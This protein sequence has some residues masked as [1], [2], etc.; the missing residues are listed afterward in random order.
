MNNL[1][2]NFLSIHDTGAPSIVVFKMCMLLDDKCSALFPPLRGEF[3]ENICEWRLHLLCGSSNTVQCHA[4]AC[5]FE[6]LVSMCLCVR[7]CA[8]WIWT[9]SGSVSSKIDSNLHVNL[10]KIRNRK[11]VIIV[12]AF[13][14]VRDRSNSDF[15]LKHIQCNI[16]WYRLSHRV[17]YLLDLLWNINF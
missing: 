11:Q 4:N 16:I 10:I 12:T 9:C 3:M 13:L 6:N 5:W 15:W 8:G 17:L 1:R 7:V 14:Y 2:W